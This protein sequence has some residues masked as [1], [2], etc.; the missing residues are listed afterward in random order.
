[1]MMSCYYDSE[2]VRVIVQPIYCSLAL[3]N[4]SLLPMTTYRC[5]LKILGCKL[6]VKQPPVL[7]HK[8]VHQLLPAFT[9]IYQDIFSPW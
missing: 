1:M 8:R 5:L 6:V 7:V 4:S 2:L 3:N 9:N